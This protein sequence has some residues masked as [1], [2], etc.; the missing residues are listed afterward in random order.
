MKVGDLV[1]IVYD[2]TVGLVTEIE[3]PPFSPGECWVRL[4]TG[5]YF[6]RDRLEVVSESR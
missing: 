5:E 1:K 2:G 6:R 3:Y 4:H